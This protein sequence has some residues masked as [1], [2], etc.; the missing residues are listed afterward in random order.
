[1]VVIVTMIMT[2][3]G[4]YESAL[5]V[6][7]SVLDGQLSDSDIMADDTEFTFKQL[8]HNNTHTRDGLSVCLS[9]SLSV[10]LS[11]LSLCFHMGLLPHLFVQ[12]NIMIVSYM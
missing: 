7:L 1:V 3:S 4:E 10:C 6:V 8:L 12:V 11:C 2:M 5:S 9:V